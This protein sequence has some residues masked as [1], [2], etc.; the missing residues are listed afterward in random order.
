MLDAIETVD[1]K[2]AVYLY[3]S[4]GTGQ[5]RAATSDVD[6]L[7]VGLDQQV[8]AELTKDLSAGFRGA[9]RGVELASARCEDFLGE[10]D[11]AY[12]NRVF[13]RHY[14][15]QLAGPEYVDGQVAFP[16]DARAA[17]G[18]NGDIAQHAQGWRKALV[19]DRVDADELGLRMARKALLALAG[20]V[21]VHDHT[22]TT[23]RARAAH[24]WGE[25]RPDSAADL[26]ALLGWAAGQPPAGERAVRRMLDTTVGAIV[27]RFEADIGLWPVGA[28][29][30]PNERTAP[31][32]SAL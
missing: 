12:G 23:D 9:C 13:L 10:T 15:V 17:R 32:G 5:A 18:F 29:V 31:Q 16:A 22:W 25:I 21:S 2:V 27:T 24:R 3:G 1:P 26:D 4:V 8:T 6:F 7:T 20:L 19:E 11:S 30:H 28:G 14:C